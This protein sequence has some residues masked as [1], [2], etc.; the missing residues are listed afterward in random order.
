MKPDSDKVIEKAASQMMEWTKMIQMAQLRLRCAE[1]VW[2]TGSQLEKTNLDESA[3]KLYDFAM[4][5]K[6]V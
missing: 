1:I 5:K 4:N 2:T 3:K 6:Q